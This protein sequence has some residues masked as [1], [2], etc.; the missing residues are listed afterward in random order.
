MSKIAIRFERFLRARARPRS[1]DAPAFAVEDRDRGRSRSRWRPSASVAISRSHTL[2]LTSSYRSRQPVSNG[3]KIMFG[4]ERFGR[5]RNVLAVRPCLE[6]DVADADRGVPRF[7]DR[8]WPVVDG[9]AGQQ[10]VR[11]EAQLL[12]AR[13]IRVEVSVVH[14]RHQP[15]ERRDDR[16]V[17]TG[18]RQPRAA[19]RER[20]RPPRA[21]RRLPASIPR[22]AS[23]DA[24][25]F[26]SSLAFSASEGVLA[27]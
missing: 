14:V 10:R 4:K 13:E 24:P 5:R 20:R 22:F 1:P 2:R 11:Q 12:V 18:G 27:P 9:A 8:E 7:L 3:D 23:V 25:S 17:R 15:L 19:A 6:A 16:R 21:A 26:R